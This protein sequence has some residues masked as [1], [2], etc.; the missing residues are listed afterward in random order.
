VSAKTCEIV[1]IASFAA[2]LSRDGPGLLLRDIAK[3]DEAEIGA[4]V[5]IINQISQIF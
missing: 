1:R 4:I 5:A 3:Q 2:P